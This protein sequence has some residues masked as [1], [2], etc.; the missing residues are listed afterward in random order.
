PLQARPLVLP[1]RCRDYLFR[2]RCCRAFDTCFRRRN[3]R[4]LPSHPGAAAGVGEGSSSPK[5][6]GRRERTSR[7]C[8]PPPSP[9]EG[10]CCLEKGHHCPG[11][12]PKQ[13]PTTT[14]GSQPRP[15][16][17]RLFRDGGTATRPS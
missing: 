12:E 17:Q 15:G 14:P 3:R 10:T 5:M 1:L 2:S 6:T 11:T 13:Q 9:A 16:S 4:L 7:C 8:V